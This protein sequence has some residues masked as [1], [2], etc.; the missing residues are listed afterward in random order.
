MDGEN[1]VRPAEVAESIPNWGLRGGVLPQIV[2]AVF[3]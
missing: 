3:I 1:W 2:L